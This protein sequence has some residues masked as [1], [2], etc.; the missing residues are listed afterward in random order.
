MAGSVRYTSPT[1][2]DVSTTRATVDWRATGWSAPDDE[3]KVTGDT[4]N[5]SRSEISYGE[6]KYS[7]SFSPGGGNDSG[8]SVTHTYTGLSAGAPRTLSASVSVSCEKTIVVI[9]WVTTTEKVQTG[10]DSEGKPVYTDKEVLKTSDPSTT[11]VTVDIG[12]A[13]NS[14]TVYTRPYSWSWSS[15]SSGAVIQQTLYASEW[16]DLIEQCRR[17]KQWSQQ[18]AFVTVNVPTVSSGDLI[19]ADLYNSMAAACGINTRVTGGSS[20][21]VISVPLFTA[22]ANAVS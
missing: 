6:L 16:N 2:G 19:T 11:N 18:S 17:Y 7:W 1:S 21:T 9:S 4:K 15:I 13:S 3:V 5:G 8:S 20:G 12:S 10:T 14:V 22:L